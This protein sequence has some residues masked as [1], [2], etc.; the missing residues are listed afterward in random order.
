MSSLILT[1]SMSTEVTQ[2][3]LHD[4]SAQCPLAWSRDLS[5]DKCCEAE[6]SEA[7]PSDADS[8]S[9]YLRFK[10]NEDPHRSNGWDSSG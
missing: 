3:Q 4:Q 1:E 6:P 9:F 2:Q 7:E 5:S 8:A 10:E